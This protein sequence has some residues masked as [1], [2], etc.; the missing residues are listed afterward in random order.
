MS[1]PLWFVA[2]GAC[3]VY[4]LLKARRTVRAFT[5]DGIGAR[6]AALGAGA[7]VFA[8]EVAAGMAERE[9]ELRTQLDLP[10]SG[11]LLLE[12]GRDGHR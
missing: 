1:R 12:E 7:R 6:V 8:D 5:P 3:G 2:G 4:T 9:T 11:R 10:G